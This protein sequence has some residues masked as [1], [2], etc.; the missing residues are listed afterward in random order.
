MI[1]GELILTEL[2]DPV[3]LQ[4]A[5]A[6]RAEVILERLLSLLSELL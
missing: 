4:P 3:L 5:E 1:V 6:V 2:D